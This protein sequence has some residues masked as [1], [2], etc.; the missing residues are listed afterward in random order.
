MTEVEKALHYIQ[1]HN[2]KSMYVPK[3]I[4]DLSNA[5]IPSSGFGGNLTG[6]RN[7][8]WGHRPLIF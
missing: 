2:K 3:D 1:S 8:Y 4:A 5:D 6:M 7:L